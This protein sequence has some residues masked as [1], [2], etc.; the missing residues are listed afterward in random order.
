MKRLTLLLTGIMMVGVVALAAAGDFHV[1][2]SLVCSDC[3]VAHYS[4]S[5]GYTVGGLFMPLGN[6]GP[7]EDLLRDDVNKVCLACHNG[8]SFAPDVFGANGGVPGVREAGGL[9]VASGNGLSNDPG[10]DVI[11]G[12]TLYST[13]LPPGHGTS[14]YVPSAEG[15]R[16]VDCHAQ[17]GIAT[18]YRNLLNRGIFTGDTL[19]Y[20]VGT[21]DLTKDVFERSAGTYTIDQIDFN[22]PNTRQSSYGRWCKTCHQD[23]HGQGGDANMGGLAGGVTSS[24]ATPWKR[25]PTADVNIGESGS[26]A[27]YI[28][29]LARYAGV[30][31]KVKVMDSQGLWTGTGTDNT[32][33]PSCMSCHKAHGN[34]NGFGLI[35]MNGT[36]TVTEEGD[37]G[38]YKDLCRQCHTE[39]A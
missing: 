4:Q 18:Q 36:G 13:A 28:S 29:S 31:N 23:F 27:T 1:G 14:A 25:H 9:T 24:N 20:A 12:H 7:Y 22:E 35:F 34:M 15:L 19:T 11:D 17:H 6:A 16:C 39:G 8:S 37:G 32:V 3:H 2:T 10:Y 38:V 5:H 33:T 26:T 21:N 30:T